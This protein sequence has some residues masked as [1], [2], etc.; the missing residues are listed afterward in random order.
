[1]AGA[2]MAAI[3]GKRHHP[4]CVWIPLLPASD[5]RFHFKGR[6]TRRQDSRL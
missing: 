3:T 1:M 5:L 2:G 6:R 4:T